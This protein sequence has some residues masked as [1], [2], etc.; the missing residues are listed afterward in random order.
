MTKVKFGP[1]YTRIEDLM[2]PV[3]LAE[4]SESW[5]YDS[6]W[7]PDYVLKPRMDA[8][9]VLGAAAQRTTNIQLGTAV[10]VLPYKDPLL[11]SK[12]ALSVDVLSNGRLLLGVGIGAIPREFEALGLDI[13]QRGRVSDERLDIM[14]RIL[15]G[16]TVTHHG[17][18]HSFENVSIGPPAVSKPRIPI[19]V[20]AHCGNGWAE[21]PLRRTGRYADAFVPT[22]ATIEQYKDAMDRISRHAEAAGRDPSKIEWAAFIF[23]IME[24]SREYAERKGF[25][26]LAD[27]LDRDYP[28]VHGRAAAAGT[29]DE[30]IEAIQAY[31]DIG[32]THFILDSASPAEEIVEQYERAAKEIIPHFR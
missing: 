27:R 23:I 7:V 21:G 12:S 9:I 31:V 14:S 4:K 16:E 22:E 5:G 24:E 1:I 15:A 28:L 17:R 18:F 8:L 25:A 3:E 11:L 2:G 29:V 13:H 26:E 10:M 32:I 30:C 20:G 6:F 19:W